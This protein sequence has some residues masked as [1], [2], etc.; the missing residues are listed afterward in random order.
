[1]KVVLLEDVKS[2]GKKG[3][4]VEVSEGYARNFI[5]PKKKG[6]EANQENL[7]TLKLQK[8]NEEKIAKEKLE[9]AK[10]LAA[11]LNEASV[12][13]TIKGGKDGRTFGSVSSK[14]IE[15]AIKSQLG[16]EIDKKKLVIAE[17]IKTFGNHEVKV[18]LH[19]DVTAALKVKVG[20]E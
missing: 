8:A 17:P 12:S 14:E 1:M 15:E 10:E 4:I 13:L 5:I 3:D 18:R 9:A 7:N 2:L 19:K 20:E 6:V 11:K 16:L